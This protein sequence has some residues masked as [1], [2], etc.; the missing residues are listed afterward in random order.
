MRQLRMEVARPLVRPSCHIGLAET[1]AKAS[2]CGSGVGDAPWA[3]RRAS[4]RSPRRNGS[5][6][7]QGAEERDSAST[8]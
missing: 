4:S 5:R 2:A 1:G 3:V 8:L 7:M 6:A